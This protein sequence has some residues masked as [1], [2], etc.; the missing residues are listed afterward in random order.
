MRSFH[1]DRSVEYEAHY[2]ADQLQD[3]P[4]GSPAVRWYHHDGTVEYEEHY[5]AGHR[6]S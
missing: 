4:D 6:V 5:Q 3:P 2:Q 1:P